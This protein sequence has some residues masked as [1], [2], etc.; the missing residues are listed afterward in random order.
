MIALGSVLLLAGVLIAPLPGP[1]GLP[2]MLIGGVLVL[3][4]SA[5]AR[6][7]YVRMTRR[8]PRIL[9]PI[10][11]LRARFRARRQKRSGA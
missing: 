7:F 9:G 11:R 6:K 4:H 8:Y 5:V 1:G 10:E 2:V 3:R